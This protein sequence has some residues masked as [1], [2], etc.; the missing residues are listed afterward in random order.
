MII[1]GLDTAEEL[2][3]AAYLA[4]ITASVIALNLPPRGNGW[5]SLDPETRAIKVAAAQR[6]I[7]LYRVEDMT[8]TYNSDEEAWREV[9]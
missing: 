2:A 6:L 7:T 8:L 1:L 4:E 9:P 5:G 3:E